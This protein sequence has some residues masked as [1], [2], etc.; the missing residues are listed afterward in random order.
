MTTPNE[1]EPPADST[2]PSS[3]AVECRDLLSLDATPETDAHCGSAALAE[4]EFARELERKL[5]YARADYEELRFHTKRYREQ[6]GERDELRVEIADL[7]KLL[8][9]WM[10][11]ASIHGWEVSYEIEAAVMEALADNGAAV[12]PEGGKESDS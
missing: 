3:E 12:P 5:N 2:T 4:A 11:E 1:N 8:R 10:T 6:V 7:K 9:R